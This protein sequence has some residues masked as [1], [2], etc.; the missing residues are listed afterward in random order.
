M[1]C[2]KCG[3]KIKKTTKICPLCGFEFV[4]NINNENNRKKFFFSLFSVLI[5]F[6]CFLFGYFVGNNADWNENSGVDASYGGY[7]GFYFILEFVYIF[8]YARVKQ[9]IHLNIFIANS[10]IIFFFATFPIFALFYAF[11]F[12]LIFPI[13]LPIL[14]YCLI[15]WFASFIELVQ[16]L[17]NGSRLSRLCLFGVF[18]CFI[19]A[20]LSFCIFR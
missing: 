3:E 11:G 10:I 18:I 8:L 16:I 12:L 15:C 1:F 4:D 13:L 14:I 17:Y 6:L 5:P 20:I 9:I 7:L 19:I 2:P